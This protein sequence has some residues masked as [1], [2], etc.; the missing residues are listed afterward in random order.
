MGVE[1]L[2]LTVGLLALG[3][4]EATRFHAGLATELAD[5]LRRVIGTVVAHA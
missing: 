1:L 2:V 3:S 4:A 5:F